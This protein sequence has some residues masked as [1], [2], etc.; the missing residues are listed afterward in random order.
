ML[1][2]L[3][4]GRLPQHE[5]LTVGDDGTVTLRLYDTDV[6]VARGARGVHVKRMLALTR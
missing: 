2:R 3:A 4:F 6:V 1:R 5:T